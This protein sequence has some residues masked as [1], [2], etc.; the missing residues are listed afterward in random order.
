MRTDRPAQTANFIH[1]LGLLVY[2]RHLPKPEPDPKP[3][4]GGFPNP[5]P[6]FGKKAPGLESLIMMGL[7]KR[8]GQTDR[9]TADLLSY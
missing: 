2:D 1:G 7:P 5:K 8:H 9:R 3:G 6:G 4:F